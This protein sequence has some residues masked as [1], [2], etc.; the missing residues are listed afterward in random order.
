MPKI[1]ILRVGCFL[2]VLDDDGVEVVATV[3]EPVPR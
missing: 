3:R 1:F 2:E